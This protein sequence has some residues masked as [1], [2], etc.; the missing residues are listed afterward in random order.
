MSSDGNVTGA[1]LYLRELYQKPWFLHTDEY[2]RL[3]VNPIKGKSGN[4]AKTHR[5]FLKGQ[6]ERNHRET[7]YPH[8]FLHF[9]SS[10]STR[11]Q[12]YSEQG[13]TRTIT[14]YFGTRPAEGSAT[15]SKWTASTLQKAAKEFEVPTGTKFLEINPDVH[16]RDILSRYPKYRKT[17]WFTDKKGR[18]SKIEGI[19]TP[20]PYCLTNQYCK[21]KKRS[22]YRRDRVRRIL[23]YKDQF[24]IPLHG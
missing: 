3:Y 6:E 22:G 13:R 5:K 1:A 12:R 15:P 8:G 18:K 4:D 2:G 7:F 23:D 21:P 9:A 24:S 11:A 19:Q 16:D 20:C 14:S 17:T 10:A